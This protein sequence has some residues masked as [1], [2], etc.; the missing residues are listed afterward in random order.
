MSSKINFDNLNVLASLY[1]KLAGR[2]IKQTVPGQFATLNL[3]YSNQSVIVCNQV[4]T[5]TLG[6]DRRIVITS[7]VLNASAPDSAETVTASANPEENILFLKEFVKF[8]NSPRNYV[9]VY[10][11]IYNVVYPVASPDDCG[12][13]NCIISQGGDVTELDAC[14]GAIGCNNNGKSCASCV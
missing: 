3:I 1:V 10:D 13:C 7:Q 14:C 9:G 4:H 5:F 8:I 11:K 6:S 2:Y 12:T